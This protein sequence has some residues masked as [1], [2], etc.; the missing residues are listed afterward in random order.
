MS[1]LQCGEVKCPTLFPPI[2]CPK[3]WINVYVTIASVSDQKSNEHRCEFSFRCFRVLP[4]LS[5]LRSLCSLT[6]CIAPLHFVSKFCVLEQSMSL[7]LYVYG[8]Q[9]KCAATA[10]E[11]EFYFD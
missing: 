5:A 1:E 6:S 9:H 3:V 8:N 2:V 11:F 7:C 10:K 4:D